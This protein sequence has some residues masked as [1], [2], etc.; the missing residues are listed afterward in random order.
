IVY[1]KDYM[2][3]GMV[4]VFGPVMDPKG[5]YGMGIIEADNEEQVK[6]FNEGDPASKINNYEFYP[7]RAVLP[8]K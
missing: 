3:K 6:K 2:S 7:M 4:I 1:W 8:D 5:T